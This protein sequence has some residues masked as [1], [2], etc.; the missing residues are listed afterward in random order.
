MIYQSTS[1]LMWIM[2]LG[3]LH[4]IMMR[5]VNS[6]CNMHI[7]HEWNRTCMD[8][9]HVDNKTCI[10]WMIEVQ[11]QSHTSHN[12]GSISTISASYS[13]NSH[14]DGSRS[15]IVYFIFI[16]I[17]LMSFVGDITSLFSKSILIYLT[18]THHLTL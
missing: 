17:I 3:K 5:C 16:N 10:H 7:W 8:R 6:L 18:Y 14:F 15:N 11:F 13:W 4:L 12:M 1:E 2:I 9:H